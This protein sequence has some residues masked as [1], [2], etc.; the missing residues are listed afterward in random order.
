MSA[1][2]KTGCLSSKS[3]FILENNHSV[4]FVYAD[5]FVCLW[6]GGQKSE[7]V[8]LLTPPDCD[9]HNVWYF[10]YPL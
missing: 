3:I 6:Q 4:A 5:G 9:Q 2:M 7:V 8:K 10:P 1:V